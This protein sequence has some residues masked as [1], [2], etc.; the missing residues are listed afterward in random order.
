MATFAEALNPVAGG[1]VELQPSP[2]LFSLP[3]RCINP[4]IRS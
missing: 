2:P 1:P 3:W 4:G